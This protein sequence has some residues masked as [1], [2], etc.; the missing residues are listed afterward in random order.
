MAPYRAMLRY[1]RCDNTPYCAIPFLRDCETTIKI[2]FPLLRGGGPW[3]QRGKSSN[4]ACFR[5]KR[6]DNKILKVQILLSSNFVVIVQAPIFLG[7]AIALHQNGAFPPS[8]YLVSHR[9]ICA[10]P[11]FAT[12]REIIMR[13]P[14]KTST[15]EF[16][17][18]IATSI[19][20]YEWPVLLL[21]L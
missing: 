1:Y 13:Y 9:H 16:C 12:Y 5:G 8:W 15:K 2:N 6:R 14:I 21:G 19:V 7:G 11:H 4:N 3:G 17:D 10:I 18:T 20:R